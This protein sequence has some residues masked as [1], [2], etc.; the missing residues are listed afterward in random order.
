MAIVIKYLKEL[1][2]FVLLAILGLLTR[3]HFMH[4]KYSIGYMK[5][6]E[7]KT[8]KMLTPDDVLSEGNGVILFE[9]SERMNPPPLVLCS[10]ESAARVY[11]ERPVAFFM[12]GLPDIDSTD[13]QTQTR[14]KFPTLSP[15]KNIYFFPL[16]MDELYKD[17]PLLDWYKKINPK[18]EKYWINVGADGSR[19]ASIWKYGGLYLDADVI[20]MRPVPHENFLAAETL[21]YC[22]NSVFGLNRHRSFTWK[23]MED[24]VKNYKG[25]VWGY[26]GPSLFTRVM[27]QWC[28][29]PPFKNTEDVT[30]GNIS[31]L[32]PERFYP[33][34]WGAWKRYYDVWE[35][36]PS[37]NNSYSLHVWNYM[38]RNNEKTMVV[39]SNTL[40][41]NLFQRYCP[42]TYASL[43][44]NVTFH[45]KPHSPLISRV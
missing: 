29:L 40:I 4:T 23:C 42:T 24:F 45:R 19:L 15:Y 43:I 18:K 1:M 44:N 7:D 6:T 31:Y 26:Q 38:N 28:V 35:E 12:K 8:L 36:L 11:P 9:I 41:E 34:P 3:L 16:R 10:I 37:F 20:S 13:Y 14:R 17:T 21:S 30:C 33:I 27:K 39:G 25:E 32:N 22:S 5:N 2:F